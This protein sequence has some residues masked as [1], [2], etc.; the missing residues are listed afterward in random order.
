MKEIL[1]NWLKKKRRSPKV[2]RLP[3]R[4]NRATAETPPASNI[5][6]ELFSVDQMERYEEVI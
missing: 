5:K 4:H 3:L 2:A 1:I 6:A